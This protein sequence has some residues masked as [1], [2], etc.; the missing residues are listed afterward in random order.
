MS[1]DQAKVEEAESNVDDADDTDEE[2][3]CIVCFPDLHIE[4]ADFA[5]AVPFCVYHVMFLQPPPRILMKR[6]RN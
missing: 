3:L 6:G 2:H 5:I 1:L 4:D